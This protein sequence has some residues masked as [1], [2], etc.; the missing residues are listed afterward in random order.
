MVVT[1]A[2][3]AINVE[4]IEIERRRDV[5]KFVQ[6]DS[7][8]LS[9]SGIRTRVQTGWTEIVASSKVTVPRD[10]T[11]SVKYVVVSVATW[12]SLPG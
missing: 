1:R 4:V 11:L 3:G 8:P 6:T 9:S 5:V 12:R 2:N 7:E 10:R